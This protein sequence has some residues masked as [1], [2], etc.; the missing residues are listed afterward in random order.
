MI[1]LRVY[2]KY[3]VLVSDGKQSLNGFISPI[4]RVVTQFKL[5]VA[6]IICNIFDD[7]RLHCSLFH[8]IYKWCGCYLM[9]FV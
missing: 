2:Y 4:G 3:W 1:V 6:K 7:F 8:L 5:S 9:Y